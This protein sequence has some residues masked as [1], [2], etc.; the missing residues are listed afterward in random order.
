MKELQKTEINSQKDSTVVQ[1]NSKTELMTDFLEQDLCAECSDNQ[2]APQQAKKQK[3]EPEF[4]IIL[5]SYRVYL[6]KDLDLLKHI[7][8]HPLP[9]TLD[10][11]KSPNK[12]IEDVAFVLGGVVD[13][14]TNNK[15]LNPIFTENYANLNST[16]LQK[17]VAKYNQILAW[18]V[19][20]EILECDNHFIVGEK[21]R[22]YRFVQKYE[23]YKIKPYDLMA[24][25]FI[26]L[27]GAKIHKKTIKDYPKLWKYFQGLKID[28]D[29]IEERL[30]RRKEQTYNDII[31]D[32][33]KKGDWKEY[34]D[35]KEEA[36][37][38]KLYPI[39]LKRE[40][41]WRLAAEKIADNTY[42][43][44]QDNNVGRLHSNLTGLKR[45]LRPLLTYKGQKLVACDIVNSQPSISV[46]LLDKNCWDKLGLTERVLKH[47]KVLRKSKTHLTQFTH[48]PVALQELLDGVIHEDIRVYRQAA[49]NGKMYELMMETYKEVTG[50]GISR[51]EIKKKYLSILFTPTY[52]NEQD[53]VYKAL[54][55]KFP[56]VFEIFE[57]VNTGYAKFKN[58]VGKSSKMKRGKNEQSAALALV[59]QELE[60]DYI[61][62]QAIRLIQANEPNLPLFTIHDSIVTT[63]GNEQI[64]KK[65]MMQAAYQFLGFT[66]QINIE[67]DKW[68]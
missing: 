67:Y 39:I 17:T 52:F 34:K 55:E 11:L 50:K 40:K 18:A 22:G 31:K 8:K 3:K 60:A 32:L 23:G 29:G 65:Y 43:F 59:L 33:K 20:S 19:E 6:P 38:K 42:C 51:D 7:K 24:K 15:D 1:K 61:L 49:L 37:N 13:T 28:L 27:K 57:W 12:L 5:D 30:E 41:Y 47:N 66:P 9:N 26:K 36:L 46:A 45:E 48:T 63:L 58:G 16:I 21:S 35:L 62:D 14:F 2:A 54:K 25:K 56:N 44:V 68:V 10:N 64:I 4:N 53:K